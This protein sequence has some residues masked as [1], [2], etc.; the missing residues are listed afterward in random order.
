[1]IGILLFLGQSRGDAL[2]GMDFNANPRW[3]VAGDEDVCKIFLRERR[4]TCRI[5]RSW[6][7]HTRRWSPEKVH[8]VFVH[9][10]ARPLVV[11]SEPGHQPWSMW[12]EPFIDDGDDDRS[13]RVRRQIRQ[14]SI[15][16]N[17]S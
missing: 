1:M 11:D 13:S 9:S 2:Q 5:C 15:P 7:Q 8:Q 4:I 14:Q 3:M 10:F 16:M 6:F 17:L 12:S